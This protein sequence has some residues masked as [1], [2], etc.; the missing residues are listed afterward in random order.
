M[1]LILIWIHHLMI[2]SQQ[3]TT[4]DLLYKYCKNVMNVTF[5]FPYIFY[6]SNLSYHNFIQIKNSNNLVN[7]F[8][9]YNFC[10]IAISKRQNLK[11]WYWKSRGRGKNWSTDWSLGF[12]FLN[13]LISRT[14]VLNR[15]VQK[16]A[17][18]P[19]QLILGWLK[20]AKNPRKHRK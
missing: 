15:Q 1:L 6:S 10:F 7:I 19:L 2:S 13:I 4:L 5:L 12:L 17:Q 3:S 9:V 14:W 18:A 11:T 20:Q 8:F 16:P